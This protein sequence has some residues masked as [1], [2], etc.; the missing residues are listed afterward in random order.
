MS[1]QI[2]YKVDPYDPYKSLQMAGLFTS[3]SLSA[4]EGSRSHPFPRTFHMDSG[5]KTYCIRKKQMFSRLKYTH[6]IH[7]R[8]TQKG[9]LKGS[10]CNFHTVVTLQL[11]GVLLLQV[12]LPAFTITINQMQVN[13]PSGGN[14][15]TFPHRLGN[16]LG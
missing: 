9:S 15:L 6:R 11:L 13:M 12:Y 4:L 14:S 7:I 8:Y 3:D 5:H 2:T 10:P 16:S 1:K